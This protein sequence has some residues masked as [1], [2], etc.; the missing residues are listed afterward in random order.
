MPVS[1]QKSR[2]G[3]ISVPMHRA[4]LEREHLLLW[5]F[6]TQGA[7]APRQERRLQSSGLT[8][9]PEKTKVRTVPVAF[10]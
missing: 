6:E 7:P 9:L 2:V 10:P 8:W 5:R 1:V 4:P 3:K